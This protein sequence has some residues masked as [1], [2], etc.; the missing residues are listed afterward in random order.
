MAGR[1][2]SRTIWEPSWLMVFGTWLMVVVFVVF[3]F[4]PLLFTLNP[5][6]FTLNSL[7]LTLV[8]LYP[9]T[10]RTHQIRVHFQAIHDPILKDKLYGP[11]IAPRS[12]G[13][14]GQ[15]F[16]RLA[17]HARRITFNNVLGEKITVEAPY[18][19]DF[20]KALEKLGL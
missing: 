9:Q 19:E 13:E 2:I 14:V 20:Q 1:M 6:L 7:P 12:L 3:C 15:A 18:P 8:E 11:K 5:S 16:S 4:S 10:G 17:L